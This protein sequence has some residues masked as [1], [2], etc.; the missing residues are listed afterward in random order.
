MAC[1][2]S[3]TEL[4]W[5]F[6]ALAISA[7]RKCVSGGPGIQVRGLGQIARGFSVSIE[8]V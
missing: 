1:L 3:S 2:N 4:A 8:V 6:W 7:K 5:S